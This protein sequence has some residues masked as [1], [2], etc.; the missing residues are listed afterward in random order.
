LGFEFFD[1]RAE[2]QCGCGGKPADLSNENR[3]SSLELSPLSDFAAQLRDAMHRSLDQ[4]QIKGSP[5]ATLI[6]DREFQRFALELFR[7][8]FDRNSPYRQFCISRA[9][10]PRTVGDW[11]EIPPMPTA[12]FAELDVTSLSEDERA[13]VYCSSGTTR[14]RPSRH[15]HSIESLSLY[16][17]SLLAW[18]LA[19]NLNGG[20]RRILSLTPPAAQ[21]S[22]SSL[23]H[24]FQTIAR[25]CA[26]GDFVFTGRAGIVGGWKLDLPETV[27]VLED[28]IARARPV[29]L[30]STA[31][32]CLELLD[33][34]RATR[35]RL[36]LPTA[37]YV[38]E[39][40]G[41][42]GRSRAL[43]RME[44]HS[45]IRDLL[46]VPFEKIVG[47]YGMCEL[48]SQAY[49]KGR[50][51]ERSEVQQSSILNPQPSVFRFPPWARVQIV[52]AETGRE[53]T[54]G[55]TGLIRVFDLANVWSMMAVQTEDLGIRRGDAFELIGRA[56]RAEP[57]GCSLMS[58]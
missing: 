9:A 20:Q 44:L 13:W 41:Y 36:E 27:G 33:H 5:Q 45:L 19:L 57:R 51:A 53:V 55:E 30:L 15:I 2:T 31:L 4:N 35:K 39:T 12:A 58:S 54:E 26:Q 38:L 43:P 10:T 50:F 8:Q 17:A 7:L 56:A 34:L 25:K 18:F 14:Q 28:S 47:E 23:A 52:S 49:D 22:N 29:L 6:D 3:M 37:S 21:A 32:T 24:M 16:D 11:R 48:S 1:N 42:K 40:G 46:G